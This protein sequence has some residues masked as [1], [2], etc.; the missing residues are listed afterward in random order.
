MKMQVALPVEFAIA[1]EAGP[2]LKAVL[3]DIINRLTRMENAMGLLDDKIT[4]LGNVVAAQGTVIE[5]AIALMDGLFDQLAAAIAAN[6]GN[7][8]A[9]VAA[10]QGVIDAAVAQKD[11]LA[12]K[13][14]ENTPTAP[15]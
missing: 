10:V 11:A 3:M 7:S 8:T 1:V 14:L 15:V 13:V 6:V 9:Q 2:E 4:E 5:S 12:A